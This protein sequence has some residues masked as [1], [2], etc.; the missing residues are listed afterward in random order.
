MSTPSPGSHLLGPNLPVRA[1]SEALEA[2]YLNMHR[3]LCILVEVPNTLNSAACL[4]EQLE[5]S[6]YLSLIHI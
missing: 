6:F 3:D 2:E 5:E 1:Y 4:C